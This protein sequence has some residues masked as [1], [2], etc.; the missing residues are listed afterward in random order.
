M[1]DMPEAELGRESKTNNC[2]GKSLTAEEE[3]SRDGIDRAGGKWDEGGDSLS[4]LCLATGRLL[5]RRLLE[6]LV[7][8]FWQ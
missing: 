6:S 2:D 4:S 5:P 1:Q 3:R 8:L 7:S